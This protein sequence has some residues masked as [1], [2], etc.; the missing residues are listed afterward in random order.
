M[1]PVIE[2]ADGSWVRDESKVLIEQ[3]EAGKY[4]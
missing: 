3:I 2:T 1:L 4:D